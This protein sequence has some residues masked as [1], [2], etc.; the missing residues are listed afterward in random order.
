MCPDG[1]YLWQ[2]VLAYRLVGVVL[3][4]Y[5]RGGSRVWNRIS[6]AA[7]L[8]HVVEFLRAGILAGNEAAERL[9]ACVV[10]QRIKQYSERPLFSY[11][12]HVPI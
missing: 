7:L 2:Y 10:N 12:E 6:S 4:K 11:D 5:C 9:R 1:W 8:L 3:P